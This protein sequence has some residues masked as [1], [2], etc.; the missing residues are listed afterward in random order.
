M[1]T[2]ATDASYF[3]CAAA[4]QKSLIKAL[5]RTMDEGRYTFA[6]MDAPNIR[7][8]EF[9]DVLAAAQVSACSPVHADPMQTLWKGFISSSCITSDL[10]CTDFCL[11]FCVQHSF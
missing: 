5:T 2:C 8:D 10:V 9:R 3:G 6:I 11:G 1:V 7:L 4:Y